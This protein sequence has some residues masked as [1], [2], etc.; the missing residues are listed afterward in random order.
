MHVADKRSRAIAKDTKMTT[1]APNTMTVPVIITID[2]S[3]DVL[4]SDA[5]RQAT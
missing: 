2:F 1:T 5:K 4:T 3:T